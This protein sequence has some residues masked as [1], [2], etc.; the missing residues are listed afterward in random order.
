M[1]NLCVAVVLLFATSRASLAAD[2]THIRHARV[3]DG[4]AVID[5]TD[6]LIR[7]GVIAQIGKDL[8]GGDSDVID[9]T[10]KTLVPG[11]IDCHV[12]IFAPAVL[13]QA[14]AFGVTTE[15]DMFMAATVAKQL[16]EEENPARADFRTAVTLATAPGGHG[17]QFGLAIDTLRGPGD[18]ETFVEARIAEGADYLKIIYDD[19]KAAG[20]KFS[21]LSPETMAAVVIAAH[22]KEKL[23]V[24]H[25]MDQESARQAI[26]AGADGFAHVFCDQPADDALIK[27]A[28]QRNVFFIPTLTVMENFGGDDGTALAT[29]PHLGPLMSGEDVA[30]LK[31]RFPRRSGA[32]ANVKT[33]IENVRRLHAGGVRILAGTDVPNPGTL[34]GVSLHRELELLVEAGLTPTEALTAA[35]AAPADA[36]K[37][38]DR[39]RIAAGK[40]ADL[41]LVDGDPTRDIKATR[42]ISAIWI[43]GKKFDRDGYRAMIDQRKK[44]LAA[45][46]AP[47]PLLVSDFEDGP[48]VKSTFG[49]G[50]S[51][52]TDEIQRGKSTCSTKIID[53]G[54]DNTKHAL[55]IKGSIN[56]PL[57]WAWAGAMFSPGPSLMAPADLSGKK[58]ISFWAK[59]DGKP[60]RIMLF[61]R[62]TGFTPAF[63]TFTPGEK[64]ERH[65]FALEQFRGNT[66]KDITMLIFAGGVEHGPFEYRIDQ[67]MFE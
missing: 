25:V 35:T 5:D 45:L 29:D 60:A 63:E 47:G 16:R 11:L 56:P 32:N 14:A 17:S 12:H 1:N 23:A 54:A 21:K 13:R 40:R 38:A 39:G 19:G 28:K 52:S 4:A 15:L 49:T 55:L 66:G 22:A 64:W 37:L 58:S 44:I 2:V 50:W 36:F 8:D 61:S 65:T 7:D 30:A 3:F 67:V 10:G 20:M 43:A 6:V 62:S 53:G 31:V 46:A 24:V 59:G 27:L 18:A 42:A 9:A 33:A 34:H 51:I 41:V 48:D 57:P 26:E